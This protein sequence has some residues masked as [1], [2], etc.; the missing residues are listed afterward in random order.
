MAD[1]RKARVSISAVYKDGTVLKDDQAVPARVDVLPIA[2]APD[3]FREL[4]IRLVVDT[5]SA[6]E[7]LE[8]LCLGTVSLSIEQMLSLVERESN[9]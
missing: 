1:F 4:S 6:E 9:K 7:L 8:G 3:R 5:N 2:G